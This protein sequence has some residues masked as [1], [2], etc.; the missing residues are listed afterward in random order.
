MTAVCGRTCKENDLDKLAMLFYW[1]MAK[2]GKS[3]FLKFIVTNLSSNIHLS[4]WLLDT[5]KK[6]KMYA[7]IPVIRYRGIDNL[8]KQFYMTFNNEVHALRE[9]YTI[10]NLQ[11][12]QNG[13][14][15]SELE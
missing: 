11:R 7:G 2:M 9:I 14:S 10:T 6:K 15:V 12:L 8:K 1:K 5:K 4:W 3:I 13:F